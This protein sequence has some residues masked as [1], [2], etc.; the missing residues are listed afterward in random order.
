MSLSIPTELSEK[1]TKIVELHTGQEILRQRMTKAKQELAQYFSKHP[2]VQTTYKVGH[3]QVRYVERQQT[4]G[5][6]QTAVKAGLTSTLKSPELVKDTLKAI[7]LQREI[8]KNYVV[9]IIKNK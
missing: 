8:K 6:T 9:E 2:N 1:L 5:L 3:R 4:S 7:L